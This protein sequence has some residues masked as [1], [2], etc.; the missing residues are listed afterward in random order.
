MKSKIGVLK[1]IPKGARTM[2]A[3]S[4]TQL[5][6]NCIVFNDLSS[7]LNLEQFA[8]KALY[9]PR[10]D[11]KGKVENKSLVSRVKENISSTQLPTSNALK[12]AGFY[13]RIESKISD[14]DVKE[15]LD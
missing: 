3:K 14:F 10:Q 2:A 7:W 13:K 5:I 6:R 9:I 1:R 12:S 15:P 11:K 4:F 8:Y